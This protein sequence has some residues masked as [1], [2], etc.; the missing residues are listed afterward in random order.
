MNGTTKKTILFAS[1]FAITILSLSGMG[2]VTAQANEGEE[3]TSAGENL[4][5]PAPDMENMTNIDI[6]SLVNAKVHSRLLEL[7]AISPPE[8]VQR[9]MEDDPRHPDNLGED[10]KVNW[11]P[12]ETSVSTPSTGSSTDH[13]HYGTIFDYDLAN[14]DGVWTRNEVH[15]VLTLGE[16][17]DI[18]YA[19]TIFPPSYSPL[20]LTT[21]YDGVSSTYTKK[22]V[23]TFDH[24]SNTWKG[25]SLTINT[26]FFSKYTTYAGGNNYYYGAVY[27][28]D[29]TWYS[30]IYNFADTQWELLAESTG[31]SSYQD[32][33]AFWEEYNLADNCPTLPQIDQEDIKIKHNGSWITASDTYADVYDTTIPCSY[34]GSHNSNYDDWEVE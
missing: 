9:F 8:K 7:G 24:T 22:S 29:G 17:E 1:L 30:M 15:N 25:V 2:L 26:D 12:E 14:I 32:G 18:L 31:S 33:W 28:S 34:S 23:K 10:G 27:K 20:E 4:V 3:V 6:E 5:A 11:Y 13:T 21:F 19:P 16:D